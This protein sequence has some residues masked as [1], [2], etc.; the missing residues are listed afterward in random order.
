[1]WTSVKALARAQVAALEVPEAAGQRFLTVSGNF[2]NQQ[3][4]NLIHESLRIPDTLKS[5]VPL[6]QPS[7]ILEGKV[8]TSNSSKAQKMLRFEGMT[9]EHLADVVADLLIQLVRVEDKTK[10]MV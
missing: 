10:A 4:A 9:G 2:D 7:E 8:Y 5:R 1:M 3:L 6:G